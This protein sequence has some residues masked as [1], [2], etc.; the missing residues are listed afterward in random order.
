[1]ENRIGQL[2]TTTNTMKGT[3]DTWKFV[4][5]ASILVAGVLGTLLGLVLR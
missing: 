5:P 1:M 4:M 3:L 2:E